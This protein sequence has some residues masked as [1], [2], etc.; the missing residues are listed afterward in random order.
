MSR[1]LPVWC[2]HL[3]GRRQKGAAPNQNKEGIR[4][5]YDGNRQDKLSRLL[6]DLPF[7]I[8]YPNIILNDKGF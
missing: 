2:V 6:H 1:S 7:F 3:I 5:P 8:S 4:T